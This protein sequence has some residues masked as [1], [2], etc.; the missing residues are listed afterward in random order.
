MKTSLKCLSFEQQQQ[1]FQEFICY[2]GWIKIAQTLLNP[3]GND[4]EDFQVNYL[5][6]RNFQ[7]FLLL[8]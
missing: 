8:M 1:L 7:V 5:I 4:D 3:W 2:L 6:D